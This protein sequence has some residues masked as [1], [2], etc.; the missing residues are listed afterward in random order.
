M[1]LLILLIFFIFIDFIDAWGC[2]GGAL[3][4]PMPGG[5][6]GG[7]WGCLGGAWGCLGGAWG[8]PGGC[9]GVLGGAKLSC[10]TF[11]LDEGK[12]EGEGG[13]KDK[14]AFIDHRLSPMVKKEGLF[15]EYFQRE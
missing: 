3:G 1:I 8:V 12:G 4:V 7:A 6:R 13:G 15:F 11:I 10:Q 2:L 14:S 9:L 5:C